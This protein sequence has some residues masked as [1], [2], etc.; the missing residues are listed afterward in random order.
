MDPKDFIDVMSRLRDLFVPVREQE[1]ESA[2]SYTKQVKT[3][4]YQQLP[5]L[6]TRPARDEDFEKFE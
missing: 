4:K 5:D 2:N 6:K 3:T 1:R